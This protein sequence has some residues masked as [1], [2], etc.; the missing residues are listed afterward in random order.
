MNECKNKLVQVPTKEWLLVDREGNCYNKKTGNRLNY[1]KDIYGYYFVSTSYNNKTVRCL[2]HRALMLAFVP[3]PDN[4]PTVNHKDGDKTNNSL[5]NLEWMNHKDQIIH[6]WACGLHEKQFGEDASSNVYPESTIREVCEMI[7]NGMRNCDILKHY[8]EMD[9]KLPSDLRTGK[10]WPHVTKDYNLQIKRR[11]RISES[12]VH[13]ICKELEKGSSV[14]DILKKTN[15]TILTYSQV[16]HIKAKN[17]YK[18]IV[19]Q[20]NF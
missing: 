20:Y 16:K 12:T 1:Q 3:N 9:V 17:S 7:Q 11:G 19:S 14:S 5:D 2:V 10:S 15:N 4:L 8:P 6:K 18:D 13:W